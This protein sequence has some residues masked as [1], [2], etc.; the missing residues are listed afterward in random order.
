[1]GVNICICNKQ[2]ENVVKDSSIDCYKKNDPS[3]YAN[4]ITANNNNIIHK[5]NSTN[6]NLEE[7][8]VD[9]MK[10][11]KILKENRRIANG[12]K[13]KPVFSSSFSNN[14]NN[15]NP[16]Q[17]D[18]K[19]NQNIIKIQSYFRKYLI[20]KN[21]KKNDEENFEKIEKEDSLC[22]KLNF[23]MNET[24]F[25]SNSL[26]NTHN[27]QENTNNQKNKNN[28][29]NNKNKEDSI[30]I[31]PFNIKN[32]FKM[33]YKYSGFVHKKDL[34]KKKSISI[35]NIEDDNSDSI[36]NKEV[37][38]SEEKSEFLKQGFGKFIF[39]DGTE[40]CGIFHENI[41]QKFGKYS[42][43]NR[44]NKDNHDKNEKEIIITDNL[45]YEEFIGEYKD[46]ISDGFGI[47]K[48]Y[49]TNL[50][51][52]GIFN[53]KGISGIGIEDSVE[54]GYTYSGDF[55]ENKKEGIGTI[56][57][58]DGNKYQGEFKNNQLNGYGIIE[59]PGQKYY[60]GELKNGRMDGFGEF[61]WK[62][63]KIYIG[64]YKNDKRN[65]FGAFIFKSNNLSNRINDNNQINNHNDDDND[66]LKNISAYIGF[67]K[68]GNMDG[69]GMKINSHEI[70]YGLWE[71][72]NKRK[73]LESNFA[74]KTYIK[75]ID[76]R[77][78][79]IILGNQSS[80]IKFLE[81]CINIDPLINPI[82]QENS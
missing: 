44:K 46:Y 55:I 77:Y 57:W 22:L 78:H 21:L 40:F 28:K 49:I 23:E 73:F 70:K 71:N 64:N 25:S 20:R 18:E 67:W 51:I 61:F 15:S 16:T 56:I 26:R 1:M 69:F 60:Q 31:V 32:K 10:Y 42:N 58:K 80:I 74:L 30:I 48:N 14:Y 50:I 41:L 19:Y 52:T 13:I 43:I 63:E 29:N 8:K 37:N 33:N 72:G 9:K 81:T 6:D 35:K 59:F 65:G 17:A 54:G 75:W 38:G 27:S 66:I 3:F 5:T 39:N 45:N 12:N 53:Y 76:K 68:N 36:E 7:K 47:Y 82:E 11:K 34:N 79:K 62:D 24:I 2:S 4:V